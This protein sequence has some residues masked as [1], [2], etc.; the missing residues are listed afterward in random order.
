MKLITA[1]HHQ[2]VKI[3]RQDTEIDKQLLEP[4]IL[5][6]GFYESDNFVCILICSK[7]N[8]NMIVVILILRQIIIPTHECV[9]F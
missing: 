4:I 8:L 6:N 7:I 9:K 5:L 1:N 3:I 2:S